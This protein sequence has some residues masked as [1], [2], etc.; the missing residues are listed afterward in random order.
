MVIMLVFGDL[1]DRVR[2]QIQD[3]G[4]HLMTLLLLAIGIEVWLSC[5]FEVLF[6]QL[7][8]TP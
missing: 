2:R 4:G 7:A 3:V 1:A 5:C 6:A 8:V